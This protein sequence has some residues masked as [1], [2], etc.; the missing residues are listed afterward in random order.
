MNMP[1]T[2][3]YSMLF[4]RVTL[5]STRNHAPMS[6][7]TRI[8][9]LSVR[10]TLMHNYAKSTH[11]PSKMRKRRNTKLKGDRAPHP[12]TQPRK[13]KAT[14]MPLDKEWRSNLH[15]QDAKPFPPKSL[16][17]CPLLEYQ[18]TPQLDRVWLQPRLHVDKTRNLLLTCSFS[19]SLCP[20]Q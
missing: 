12:A 15:L 18:L 9:I 4:S 6:Q 20:F 7:S 5:Q 11:F 8:V 2:K 13:A 10:I 14:Q 19:N 3:Y 16:L 1:S 17:H